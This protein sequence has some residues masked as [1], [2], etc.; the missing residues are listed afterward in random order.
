MAFDRIPLEQS[1]HSLE[2]RSLVTEMQDSSTLVDVMKKKTAGMMTH[3][4][5]NRKQWTA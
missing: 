3:K 5:S 1:Y 2:L 4:L